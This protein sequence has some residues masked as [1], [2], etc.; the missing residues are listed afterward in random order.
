M[1][2]SWIRSGMEKPK[3]MLSRIEKDSVRSAFEL[4]VVLYL[5]LRVIITIG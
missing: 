1:E 5:Q 2:R 4:V 3:I